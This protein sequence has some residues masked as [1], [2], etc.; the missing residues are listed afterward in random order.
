MNKNSIIMI[1]SSAILVLIFFIIFIIFNSYKINFNRFNSKFVP[2]ED[3]Y[4][5]EDSEIKSRWYYENCYPSDS[6]EFIASKE[7]RKKEE[8]EKKNKILANKE[9]AKKVALEKKLKEEKLALE[10]KLKEEDLKRS[11]NE[12][13]IIIERYNSIVRHCQNVGKSEGMYGGGPNSGIFDY[14]RDSN[15]AFNQ[16]MERNRCYSV[17][18][19]GR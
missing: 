5:Y 10:K 6:H 1:L 3:C 4:I 13:T 17:N 9:K 18:N 2:H 12:A 14:M 19:C 11:N 8:E 7:L 15:K 16:C